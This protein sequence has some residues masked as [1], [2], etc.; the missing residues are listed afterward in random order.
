[1][2][3][4]A[5]AAIKGQWPGKDEGW[6]EWA[7][8][9]LGMTLFSGIPIARDISNWKLGGHSCSATP[10]TQAIETLGQTWDDLE[11]MASGEKTSKHW[12]NPS[13]TF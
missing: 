8:K 12:L 2:P 10:A 11:K 13:L 1:M 4:M 5:R 3:L 6:K 7:A 9:E